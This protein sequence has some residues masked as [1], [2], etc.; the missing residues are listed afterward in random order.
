VRPSWA[1]LAVAGPLL[2]G[3][4]AGPSLDVEAMAAAAV[5]PS[6]AAKSR[7]LAEDVRALLP[8]GLR[9]TE[10]S[11][12]AALPNGDRW[13]C[14]RGQAGGSGGPARPFTAVVVLSPDAEL[15]GAQADCPSCRAAALGWQPFPEM[16]GPG[17]PGI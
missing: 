2:A 17:E 1:A 6:E 8:A 16:D 5:P 4:A 14:L 11:D 7:L 9:G 15:V 10:L 3:C 13:L 12:V